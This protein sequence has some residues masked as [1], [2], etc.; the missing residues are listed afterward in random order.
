MTTMSFSGEACLASRPQPTAPLKP[1]PVAAGGTHRPLRPIS[2]PEKSPLPKELE[3]LE[4]EA[5]RQALSRVLQRTSPLW[6]TTIGPLLSDSANHIFRLEDEIVARV[7]RQH[8]PL[9]RTVAE[10]RIQHQLHDGG[11]P[12]ARPLG[13]F[14]P[15]NGRV[16]TFYHLPYGTNSGLFNEADGEALARLHRFPVDGIRPSSP[17]LL[18]ETR[19]AAIEQLAN[20]ER[21]GRTKLRAIRQLHRAADTLDARRLETSRPAVIH[22]DFHRESI[23]HTAR[24]SVLVDF[25]SV[26]VGTIEEEFARAEHR[27]GHHAAELRSA[28]G[29]L[30]Y[31]KGLLAGYRQAGGVVDP[32]LV[33]DLMPIFDFNAVLIA[34]LRG[35]S[36]EWWRAEAARRLEGFHVAGGLLRSDPYFPWFSKPG[37]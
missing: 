8:A 30:S 4:A 19:I 27:Y 13:D 9:A 21:L 15:E 26:G 34:V 2:A 20:Q 14:Y 25:D 10:R 33:R 24:G 5:S 29:E 3:D 16:V 12:V 1:T 18:A 6:G 36:D 31:R 17:L 7:T 28:R 37:F 35:A 32:D 11:V 22:G 23:F